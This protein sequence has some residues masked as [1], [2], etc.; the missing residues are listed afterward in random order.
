MVNKNNGKKTDIVEINSKNISEHP[1]VICFINPSHPSYSLK[2]QWLK[3]RFREGLKI[4]LFYREHD[5]KCIGFIEYTP[6]EFAW[7]AVDARGYFFI[8][9]IWV[10]KNRYRNRGLGSILINECLN[11]AKTQDKNGIAVIASE[12]P[13]MASNNLFKKNRFRLTDTSG[14]YTLLVKQLKKG[15]LPSFKNW[16]KELKKYRGLNIIYSHQCPW[17]A[18]SIDEL[19]KISIKNKLKIKLKQLKTARQAQNAPS[20]YGVFTLIHNGKILADHYISGRRFQNILQKEIL[21]VKS[22][23]FHPTS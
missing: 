17:V 23:G 3:K 10:Y 16:Q 1:E 2:L 18:R 6:G 4:K 7:R 5:T 14:V 22:N 21:C 12:G 15:P 19:R 20:I 11:D 13:F 9:C 8:H